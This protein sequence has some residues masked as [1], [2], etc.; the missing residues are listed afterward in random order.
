MMVYGECGVIAPRIPNLGATQRRMVSSTTQVHY[1]RGN[2]SVRL[3]N[4]KLDGHQCG[5]GLFGDDK[6]LLHLPEIES[7]F[8][9]PPADSLVPIPAEL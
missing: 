1:P 3:L 9:G 2:Y 6:N 5:S 4:C 8:L 7:R